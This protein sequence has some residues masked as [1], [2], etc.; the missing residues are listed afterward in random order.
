MKWNKSHQSGI[1]KAKAI[2]ITKRKIEFKKTYDPEVDDWENKKAQP[3]NPAG[4]KPAK[5][6]FK[7][8]TTAMAEAIYKLYSLIPTS[9]KN[10]QD[11]FKKLLKLKAV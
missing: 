3:N 10:A 8:V 1:Q 7:T 11:D 5:I 2:R 9:D 4:K 6:L